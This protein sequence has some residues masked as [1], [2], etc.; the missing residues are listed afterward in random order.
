MAQLSFITTKKLSELLLKASSRGD[1]YASVSD[2]R[3]AV[4]PDPMKPSSYVDLSSEEIVSLHDEWRREPEPSQSEPRTRNTGVY[5]L[6]V[7][8]K[9]TEHTRQRDVLAEGLKA[10][11]ALRPGTLAKLSEVKSRTRR[12]VARDP[13]EL[14]DKTHLAEKHVS[15]L[16]DGWYYGTNNSAQETN[17]WLREGAELAGLRWGKDISTTL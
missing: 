11:E 13:R 14:F 16:M 12:I 1:L 17:R 10:I 4:G 9:T 7:K 3:L 8:G 5:L 6:E 15:K 2:G